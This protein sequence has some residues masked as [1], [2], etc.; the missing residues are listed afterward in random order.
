MFDIRLALMTGVDIPIPECQLT[1]RQPTIREI[2]MI[3][4]RE[5]F[6]GAQVLCMDKAGNQ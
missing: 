3:G 4:E 2:S 5:F 1:L 6:T